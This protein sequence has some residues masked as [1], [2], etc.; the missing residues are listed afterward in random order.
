[1]KKPRLIAFEI[2][3]EVLYQDG[4]SNLLLQKKL[5][6]YPSYDKSLITK[7][8]YGTIQNYDL[9]LYQLT[10]VKYDKLSNK[11]KVILAMSLYQKH[12]LEKIPDYSIV[13]EAIEIAKIVGNQYQAKFVGALLHELITK[14]LIYADTA[15]EDVNLAINYSHPL[16]LIKML[17]KQYRKDILVQY[18]KHNQGNAQIHLRYNINSQQ[19]ALLEADELI[20]KLGDNAYLYKGQNIINYPFYQE[21]IVSVQDINSQK[22]APFL[23]PDLK[24]NVLDMC[25]APGSKTTHLAEIMQNKGHIKAYDIHPHKIKLITKQAERLHLN[26]I[27][28]HAY[29]AT[30][31]LEVENPASFDYILCD[32]PCTGLG[33]IKRK[34]EIKYHN[35]MDEIIPIQSALLQ[36]AYHLLKKDGILVYSTCTINK[37][38]NNKQIELLL[39]NHDDLILIEEKTLFNFE[40][41]G[42]CFYM[43]KLKKVA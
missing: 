18:L 9:L 11:N 3:Y 2:I 8:V 22:V 27:S 7:I 37:K 23:S 14:P 31:L 38:E 12:F 10:Q 25:A 36:Q 13:N 16:Y 34:P 15:D 40:T 43:A 32:A 6:D 28:A 29:D 21:G 5:D 20:E 41:N 17:K 39:K 24:G 42:D 4:Y 1:M 30:K 35:N 19:R 26:N 33:V